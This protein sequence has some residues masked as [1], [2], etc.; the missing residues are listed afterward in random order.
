[1]EQMFFD[2]SVRTLSGLSLYS[3]YVLYSIYIVY[4]I[5]VAHGV[6]HSLTLQRPVGLDAQYQSGR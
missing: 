4:V 3:I 2:V 1:M 6:T 5:G